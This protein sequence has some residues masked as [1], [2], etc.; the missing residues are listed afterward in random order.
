MAMIN[1]PECNH[2]ISDKAHFCPHCGRPTSLMPKPVPDKK[3]VLSKGSEYSNPFATFLRVLAV[4][5]AISGLI[6]AIVF[7]QQKV[8]TYYRSETVFSW[9]FFFGVLIGSLLSAFMLWSM[10]GIVD[11]IQ[12]TYDM[13]NGLRIE[14][15]DEAAP[16]GYRTSNA[17]ARPL[18]SVATS[19]TPSG[20]TWRCPKCGK[21]NAASDRVCKDC[22]QWK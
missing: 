1:C 9:G 18:S 11:M 2:E 15:V 12:G 5:T 22:G 14:Q 7:S 3:I 6:V 17:T 8:T 21:E 13:I 4:L 16:S 19:A 20:K 10:G